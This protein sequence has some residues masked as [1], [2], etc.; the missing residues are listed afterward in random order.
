[1]EICP[2]CRD[3]DAYHC[4]CGGRFCVSCLLKHQEHCS[5]H[6]QA[7]YQKYV[8]KAAER[9]LALLSWEAWKQ[10]LS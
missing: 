8:A 4:E 2:D 1:M 5:P 9:G 6:Q 7:R 10:A 3:N